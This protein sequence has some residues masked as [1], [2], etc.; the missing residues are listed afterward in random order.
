M[1]DP[2]E[3]YEINPG[4]KVTLRVKI[5]IPEDA[6]AGEYDVNA[7]FK[8]VVE[9]TGGV[10]II[11]SIGFSFPVIVP[12]EIV[13]TEAEPVDKAIERTEEVGGSPPIEARGE[14]ALEFERNKIFFLFVGV[15]LLVVIV[16]YL[17]KTKS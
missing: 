9:S 4:E 1:I 3:N 10:Q 8:P 2:Q 7:F 13:E 17:V 6:A 12:G 15:V 11:E 14:S 16:F 5:E